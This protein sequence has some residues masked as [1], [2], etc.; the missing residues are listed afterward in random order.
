MNF[1]LPFLPER[2]VKPRSSGLTMVM[3]KGLSVREAEDLIDSAGHLID[4]VK[5]GFGTSYLTPRLE[6]KIKLYKEANIKTYLGGTL[7]EVFLIRGM[8]DDYRKLIDRLGVDTAEVSDGC[9]PLPHDEKCEYIRQLAQQVTVLSEVGS[10]MEDSYASPEKWAADMRAELDA[11]SWKVIAEARESGTI[12]IYNSSGKAHTELIDTI[13]RKVN[14]DD[15][16]WEAPKKPQQVWFIQ[17]LGANVN[18]GNIGPADVIPCET[19]RLGLRGDTF[20]TFLPDEITQNEN[21]NLIS[22]KS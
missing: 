2:P 5:F 18:L 1:E 17:Y 22:G 12:G 15:I 16:I 11:G 4:V 21:A 9:H 13:L 19:L 7:L 8:F 10:K 20:F 14:G 3:D 6:E